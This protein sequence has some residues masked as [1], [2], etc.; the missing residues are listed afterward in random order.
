MTPDDD[1]SG[2]KNDVTV[3][4]QRIIFIPT[5]IDSTLIN[6]RVM[7][8]KSINLSELTQEDLDLTINMKKRHVDVQI[9]RVITLQ[10]NQND[11]TRYTRSN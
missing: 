11:I 1:N 4:A 2:N 9:M 7:R 10:A 8:T 5:P 3:R 6:I